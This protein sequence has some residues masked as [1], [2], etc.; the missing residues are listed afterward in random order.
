MKNSQKI[1]RMILWI[2]AIYTGIIAL[3]FAHIALEHWVNFID[4]IRY[5]LTGGGGGKS[6]LLPLIA[7]SLVTAFTL[8]IARVLI[9]RS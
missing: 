5:P 3:Y 7:W 8:R 6:H 1:E 9:K 2:I 4:F